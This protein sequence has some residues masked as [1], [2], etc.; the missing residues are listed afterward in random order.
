MEN[1]EY[2]SF[3]MMYELTQVY[4]DVS[5]KVKEDESERLLGIAEG[6]G[7]VSDEVLNTKDENGKIDGKEL[8]EFLCFWIKKFLGLPVLAEDAVENYSFFMWAEIWDIFNEDN[9]EDEKEKA[10][11]RSIAIAN[12]LSLVAGELIDQEDKEGK[13]DKDYLYDFLLEWRKRFTDRSHQLDE[14]VTSHVITF[15]K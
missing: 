8:Y 14:E 7:V 13:I 3:E 4:G 10:G 1:D 5:D 11:R 2:Y 12:G 6:L 9:D 15:K